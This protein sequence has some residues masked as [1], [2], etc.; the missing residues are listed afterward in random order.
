MTIV[1]P[2]QFSKSLRTGV[3]I[4]G[5]FGIVTGAMAWFQAQNERRIDTEDVDRRAR[6]LAHQLFLRSCCAQAI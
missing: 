1:P 3:L 2:S 6:A 4:A 5:A